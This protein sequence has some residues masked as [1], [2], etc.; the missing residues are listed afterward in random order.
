M[1]ALKSINLL[2]LASIAGAELFSGVV[3]AVAVFYP[4][5]SLGGAPVTDSFGSGLIMGQIF[6]KLAI[7]SLA[8]S[9]F[10]ALYELIALS[11]NYSK[12]EKILKILLVLLNL[13]LSL[14]FVFY[15][16]Q[17][18][19][20]LQAEILLGNQGIEVL[21]SAEFQDLHK[22]SELCVKALLLSQVIL[23]FLSFKSAKK[24]YNR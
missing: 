13:A 6:H 18:M 22:Q 14:L 17:P 16:T 4:P 5:L 23:Y 15:Y 11:Q 20:N 19:L 10:N 3:V 2:L 8:V 21:A 12:F 7:A 9:V 24:E 1:N